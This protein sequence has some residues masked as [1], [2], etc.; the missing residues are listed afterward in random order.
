MMC[1]GQDVDM[2]G[3]GAPVFALVIGGHCQPVD[4]SDDSGGGRSRERGACGR[5]AQVARFSARAKAT[6]QLG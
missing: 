2:V 3:P 6:S 1:S 5:I 4:P